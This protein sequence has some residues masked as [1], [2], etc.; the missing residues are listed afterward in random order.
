MTTI[1][2]SSLKPPLIASTTPRIDALRIERLLFA[3]T[4]VFAAGLVWLAPRLPMVDLPQHA[5]QVTL[6]RDLILGRSPWSDLVRIN[7]MTPY[8]IGYA[9]TLPFSIVL[10]IEDAIRLVL[11]LTFAGYM[12]A[13][14]ALR[15]SFGGD[16]RLDWLFF[17]GFYGFAW[18]FGFL[19]FLVAAP[20][21]L[22]F[23]LVSDRF[24]RSPTIRGACGVFAVGIALLFSHGPQFLSRATRRAATGAWP[25]CLCPS[26]FLL[27]WCSHSAG[28]PPRP[29]VQCNST[30]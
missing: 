8:L 23:V 13:C 4:I 26:P 12:A 2:S 28:R 3:A 16:P 11:S 7:L 27:S 5:A 29:T 19:T 18:Q 15:R 10:P 14:I 6:W 17:F 30:R 24:A 22:F 21:A 25:W 1:D 20:V 9:F